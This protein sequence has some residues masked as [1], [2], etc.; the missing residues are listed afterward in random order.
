MVPAKCCATESRGN[1]SCRACVPRVC[2]GVFEPFKSVFL[3]FPSVGRTV[4]MG[5][6]RY[7]IIII[8]LCYSR[9]RLLLRDIATSRALRLNTTSV[10]NGREINKLRLVVRV[11]CRIYTCSRTSA[12]QCASGTILSCCEENTPPPPSPVHAAVDVYGP[13]ATERS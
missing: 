8:V 11:R 5:W 1:Q 13:F 12:G 4:W 10:G 6:L 9:S 3:T 7:R 2:R